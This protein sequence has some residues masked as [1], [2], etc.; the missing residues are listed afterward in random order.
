MLLVFK[1]GSMW[2]FEPS[3]LT[4]SPGHLHTEKYTPK[5]KGCGATYTSPGVL[6]D[7]TLK[8]STQRTQKIH[9]LRC[10][11]KLQCG[12]N[13]ALLGWDGKRG[14]RYQVHII[15]S[16]LRWLRGNRFKRQCRG[17]NLWKPVALLGFF[18]G[19]CLTVLCIEL[20][21]A[22]CSVPSHC[23]GKSEPLE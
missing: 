2:R 18:F 3:R 11:S 15:M 4:V 1:I 19:F 16:G 17:R 21:A 7:S 14:F 13:E 22:A 9:I 23:C 6:T 8:L 12:G 20:K 10:S 5:T